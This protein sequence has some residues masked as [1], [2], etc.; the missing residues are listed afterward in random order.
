MGGGRKNLSPEV[1]AIR[2]G[3]TVVVGLIVLIA[4]VFLIGEKET[5]FARKVSYFIEFD[6]V[7]GLSSGSFVQLNGVIVG[8][9]KD[10]VSI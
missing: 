10:V 6:S 5:L 4:G 8:K 9:V 2:V 3:I 1:R 7:G